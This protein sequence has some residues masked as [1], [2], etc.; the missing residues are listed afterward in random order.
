VSRRTLPSW[1]R[2]AD[3]WAEDPAVEKCSEGARLMFALMIGQAHRQDTDGAVTWA[4]ILR[5]GV[6]RPRVK[7]RELIEAGLCAEENGGVHLKAY[8]KWNESKAERQARSEIAAANGSAGGAATR[9][10]RAAAGVSPGDRPNDAAYT[11]GEGSNLLDDLPSKQPSRVEVEQSREGLGGRP[12]PPPVRAGVS[13]R[14]IHTITD[15]EALD[16]L[17]QARLD[18]ERERQER[19]G[20]R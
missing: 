18:A 2:M 16:T 13:R 8:L 4:W 11:S 17:Q 14:G 15:P 12:T 3:D 5:S 6:R 10:A 7:A 20:T 9:A 1:H 19:E